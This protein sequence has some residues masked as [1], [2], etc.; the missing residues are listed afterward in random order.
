MFRVILIDD[1]PLI[2]EGLK[3]VVRWEEYCGKRRGTDP[4]PPA[5]YSLY[6]YSHARC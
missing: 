5:G 1:E 6:R 4:H 3:K 2:V